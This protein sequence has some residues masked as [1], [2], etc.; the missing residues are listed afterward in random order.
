IP[1]SLSLF[2]TIPPKVSLNKPRPDLVWL[3]TV[4]LALIVQ[5]RDS[6]PPP[7]G[8]LVSSKSNRSLMNVVSTNS[9]VD[10]SG[11]RQKPP[12]QLNLS[13]SP[14]ILP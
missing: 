1:E 7:P 4:H 14:L 9:D 13:L 11:R 12:L 3:A 6:L 8:Q 2:H 5:R 10:E